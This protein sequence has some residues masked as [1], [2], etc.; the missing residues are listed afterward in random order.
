MN[1][2][3]DL[4][5]KE[6]VQR[7]L[8]GESCVDAT[9]AMNSRLHDDEAH[10]NQHSGERSAYKVIMQPFVCCLTLAAP[11]QADDGYYLGDLHH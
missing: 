10:K 4:G 2:S 5:L 6:S 8:R 7:N 11:L 3:T 9:T 1:G